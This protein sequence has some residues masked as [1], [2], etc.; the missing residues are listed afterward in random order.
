[1]NLDE[2]LKQE[3]FEVPTPLVIEGTTEFEYYQHVPGAYEGKLGK[4]MIKYVDMDGKK[5]EKDTPGAKPKHGLL[6]IFITASP[7]GHGFSE[8]EERKYGEMMYKLYIP[9]EPERQW[10]NKNLFEL[11]K[12]EPVKIV[13]IVSE[14]DFKVNVGN[15]IYFIGRDVAFQLSVSS[16]GNTFLKSLFLTDKSPFTQ[17]KYLKN[18]ELIKKWYAI[19]DAALE[20]EKSKS[21]KS[22]DVDNIFKNTA[23]GATSSSVN[24]LST[25]GLNP[26]DY[27]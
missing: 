1:M 10:Q 22:E 26:A 23:A 4:F 13:A 16:K 2:L 7:D 20:K 11:F 18:L 21:K 8:K 15:L 25:A 27:E 12:I 6:D 14:R 3:G 17:E 24:I 5:C 9:L 19:A